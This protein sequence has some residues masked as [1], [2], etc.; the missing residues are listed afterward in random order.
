M[1]LKT[2]RTA[3][4]E[5]MENVSTEKGSRTQR[6]RSA[7]EDSANLMTGV[8][9]SPSSAKTGNSAKNMAASSRSSPRIAR[10]GIGALDTE[11]DVTPR[12]LIQNMLTIQGTAQPV[13]RRQKRVSEHA[14]PPPQ[15]SSTRRRGRRRSSLA[16]PDL[17]DVT[18]KF[19]PRTNIAGFLEQAPEETPAMR[20]AVSL[21]S[22]SHTAANI[23]SF[24]LN[25]VGVSM[26]E[27]RSGS[28]T[29]TNLTAREVRARSRKR[30]LNIPLPQATPSVPR[31]PN[32]TSSP[33]HHDT[34]TPEQVRE[35]ENIA[36]DS[37][38]MT[39]SR[40]TLFLK[41]P[42]TDQPERDRDEQALGITPSNRGTSTL[43]HEDDAADS[44]DKD[45]NR[46]G[47]R[48]IF[49]DVFGQMERT[50]PAL[51]AVLAADTEVSVGELGAQDEQGVGETDGSGSWTQHAGVITP[52]QRSQASMEGGDKTSAPASTRTSA[53]KKAAE[54]ESG[55]FRLLGRRTT[56][57]H[58]Q[59]DSQGGDKTPTPVSTR[60]SARRKGF[61][62]A[63][64]SGGRN[65]S[66]VPEGE[67]DKTSTPASASRSRDERVNLRGAKRSLE[68][69]ADAAGGSQTPTPSKRARSGDSPQARESAASL[70]RSP[71][72]SRTPSSSRRDSRS[73][74]PQK[75]SSSRN[76]MSPS[77]AASIQGSESPRSALKST[78]Q[79]NAYQAQTP[80][81][82][83]TK[84]M[85]PSMTIQN[86]SLSAIA[87]PSRH[88]TSQLHSQVE[89]TPPRV[90]SG[91]R[92]PRT[93]TPRPSHVLEGTMQHPHTPGN[94]GDSQSVSRHAELGASLADNESLE[95]EEDGEGYSPLKTPRLPQKQPTPA[96]H[97]QPR[98]RSVATDKLSAQRGGKRRA[99][100]SSHAA[101]KPCRGLPTSVVKATFTHFCRL[102]VSKEAI[103]EVEKIS[104]QYWKNMAED[105]E[106]YATHAHRKM[107]DET[108]VHLLMR[109]QGFITDKCALNTLIATYLPLE[110]RQELIPIARSGNKLEPSH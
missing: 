21:G 70:R 11:K 98:N 72:K 69:V 46:S 68:Y 49:S 2:P 32:L 93:S 79:R 99:P 105:L 26:L 9:A 40:G 58:S 35:E 47:D 84:N 41:T 15:S 110:Q 36:G 51:P 43:N 12:H 38:S 60:A 88:P 7:V 52:S 96:T 71:R 106:A 65:K 89:G 34:Q 80:Q 75:P 39:V 76:T 74:T 108:D 62:P 20:P 31:E 102:R 100:G 64:S 97:T 85:Q 61:S 48:N 103:E 6:R 63:P 5:Y 104:E 45:P 77:P 24:T 37:V 107:I 18:R 109:R 83:R 16:A 86:A 66:G 22:D 82:D 14:M 42:T 101:T 44:T 57:R 25:E 94:A 50:S 73:S 95:S 1:A 59:A 54:D 29:V 78:E 92:G 91:V 17:E 56:P 3:L 53:R 10:S 28:A 33:S 90:G 4:Q 55:A 13:T 8:S 23:S 67:T 87:S 27:R 30:N 81:L 19:T